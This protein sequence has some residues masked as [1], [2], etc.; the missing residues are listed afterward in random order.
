VKILGDGEVTKKFSLKVNAVS[1]SAREKLEK[2]GGSI[3]LIAGKTYP[4][5]NSAKVIALTSK[6]AK[7][8]GQ[9]STPGKKA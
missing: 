9:P 4:A 2:A 3:E 6:P 1:A 8:K 5:R 7:V